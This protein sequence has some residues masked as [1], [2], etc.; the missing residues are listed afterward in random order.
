MRPPHT[1][2]KRLQTRPYF[3]REC[4]KRLRR[5]TRGS[6]ETCFQ[7]ATNSSSDISPF[8]SVSTSLNIAIA[9]NLAA[10]KAKRA[11]HAGIR[12]CGNVSDKFLDKVRALPHQQRARTQSLSYNPCAR[13]LGLETKWP[14]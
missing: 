3:H 6:K 11:K 5:H 12:G 7:N 14:S 1:S 9:L 4:Q 8:W 2:A 13:S 10:V